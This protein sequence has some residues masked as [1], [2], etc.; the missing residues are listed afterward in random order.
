MAQLNK[1][2]QI[3]KYH[4][5]L[6]AG[7]A[8]MWNLS[9]DGWGGDTRVMTEE[10]V[11]KKEAN[12]DNIE[13]YLALDGEEVVGYC[14]LSEYKEDT[15]SLYIPLLNVRPDYQGHKIGKKLVLQAL[16]KTV[17]LGWP[18][19]DLYTWAG[20]TKAVPLYK[21][22][23]FFWEDRDD[24][25]HLMNFIPQVLNTPLLK[26]VFEKVDW[27]ENS[28]RLI[29][30]KP[31]GIKEN[32]FTFYEYSWQNGDTSA[33]VHFERTSRGISLIETDEF[34]LQMKMADH[35]VIQEE[36][37]DFEITVV[38]KGGSPL[39]FKAGGTDDGRVKYDF[40]A[41][42]IVEEELTISAP[43]TVE[44]GEEPSHWRTHP[45]IK[46]TVWINGLACELKLGVFPINPAK[47]EASCSGNLSF[48]E[49]E[50]S[51]EV[52]ITNNLRESAEFLVNFPED[53]QVVLE[54][55]SF[56][57][58]VPAGGR[59]SVS[60]PLTVKQHG[61]YNPELT[62]TAAKADGQKLVF[63]QEVSVAFKGL[64]EK[65]G[66]ESKD[67]WHIFNGLGQINVRKRDLLTTAARNTKKN[68]PVAF[69]TPKL[70]KPYSLEFTKKKPSSVT[71]E[72]QDSWIDLK[73]VLES[74]EME[75]MHVT[76]TYRLFG[77]GILHTWAEV[78][79]KG[80]SI[81]PD[82]AF[83]QPVYHDLEQVYFPLDGDVVYFSENRIMEIGE[84]DSKRITGNWYFS[85]GPSGKIGLAWSEDSSA[86]PESWQ[87]IIEDQFGK[88]EPGDKAA[89]GIITLSLGA[90]QH[91]DEFIEYAQQR[92]VQKKIDPANELSF[93]VD[94]LVITPDT[95]PAVT[96][97]TYRNSYLDGVLTVGNETHAIAAETE[98]TAYSTTVPHSA[99]EPV[100]I[101]EAAY[102]GNGT[103][104]R[105]RELLLSPSGSVSA[106]MQDG[107]FVIDNGVVTL[108][109]DPG[110]YPGLYSLIVDG[111][112]WLDHSYPELAAKSWWNPWAGGMKTAPNGINT[113][114]LLNESSHAKVVEVTD[115]EGNKWSGLGITTE[116]SEHKQWKGVQYTQYYL[117][118]PGVPVVA[119]F[120]EVNDHAGKNLVDEVWIT[121]L[122]LGGNK[123][124]DVQISVN[125]RQQG[126]A[127]HAGSQEIP[128]LL[129]GDSY[130]SSNSSKDKLYFVPN[131]EALPT[132]AYTN[133][134]VL[135]LAS[136]HK[137]EFTK[138]SPLFMLFDK[139]R[140]TGDLL[141]KLR[142][143]QF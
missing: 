4:E 32:E 42:E 63:E 31:D 29:E 94:E 125:D 13:L 2:I 35:E 36:K 54:N 99:A 40:T 6:A 90:F 111:H 122:F 103:E 86:G 26:P 108:K 50:T 143:V 7:V 116:F 113:F 78:E 79:N 39:S 135:Q 58:D 121:D 37:R 132:E 16:D 49:N 127:Y 83:S 92:P 93:K 45:G 12:S 70:G 77:D 47:I 96:L 52:E 106:E 30:V 19:L 142:R 21:K 25:T 98:K 80:G 85:E 74:A 17:E 97:K 14:G 101:L 9:R 48:L 124:T 81:F 140:L 87:F 133:K 59:K 82:V 131:N 115:R 65:F 118:L 88:M 91:V 120:T 55:R 123:L 28:T 102:A 69:L 126:Y 109:A 43:F 114:S 51:I 68:Q 84:L 62:I 44:K 1:V 46:A 119:S 104:A 57:V 23:G 137:G 105:F 41:E 56:T 24:S 15:G 100:S 66:G 10:Q 38:N 110:F 67:F 128:L 76:Q 141:K 61:F 75:G 8:R 20:N 3:V 27:Y 5:G 139:R 34:L 33:R 136:K 18:R 129:D 22:C 107:T 117:M 73:I 53:D 138:S 71:W 72:K 64:G 112:E 60:V 130:F 134:E 95:D 89:S 11:K